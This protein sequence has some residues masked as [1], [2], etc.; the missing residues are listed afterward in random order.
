MRAVDKV[1]TLLTKV[2]CPVSRR[3]SV[4][5]EQ[6]DLF[7]MSSDLP[8]WKILRY[9][10]RRLQ[11]N[12]PQCHRRIHSRKISSHQNVV[13]SASCCGSQF[14]GSRI[15]WLRERASAE[16]MGLISMYKDLGKPMNGMLAIVARR[17]LGKLR[18]LDTNHLWIQEKA[19]KGDLN[20]KKVAG[21]DNGADLF[22]RYL[23]PEPFPVR[24]CTVFFPFTSASGFAS[25]S[26]YNPVSLFHTCCHGTCERRNKCA[27]ISGASLLFEYGFS[28][29]FSSRPRRNRISRKHDGGEN[30]WNL[31]TVTALHAKRGQDRKLRPDACSDSCRT[32]YQD[33]KYWTNY[34]E[35]RGSRHFFGTKCS[36]W[37]QH[38]I[39]QDL[40]TCLDRVTA[41]QPLGP[42]GPMAQGHPMTKEYKTQTWYF[43]KPCWWTCAKCRLTSIPLWTVPYWNYEVDQYSLGTVQHTSRQ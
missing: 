43:L 39:Q 8:T 7:P 15:A 38:L 29:G 26:V 36:F 35:P 27:D 16:T 37:F 22:R 34:W 11:K 32:D 19:A 40:G 2:C 18:H 17:G 6:G 33:Y 23:A 4:M 41:P 9:R 21:V 12:A 3:L 28:S 1:I 20:F 25:P 10:L 30:Q 5:L 13:Q 14:S 42:S 24:T 31:L